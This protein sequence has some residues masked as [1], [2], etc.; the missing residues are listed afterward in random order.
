MTMNTYRSMSGRNFVSGLAAAAITTVLA[1]ALVESFDPVQLQRI[2][3]Q[4]ASAPI[5]TAEVRRSDAQ[6]DEA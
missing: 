6:A 1:S 5:A 3:D 2:E 4:A